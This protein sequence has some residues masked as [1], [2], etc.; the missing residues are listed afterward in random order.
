VSFT[1]LS[2]GLAVRASDERTPGQESVLAA[3][4]E[5]YYV[6]ETERYCGALIGIESESS[7][8]SYRTNQCYG[9]FVFLR[10]I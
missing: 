8:V 5:I 6:D 4:I 1:E 9:H 2:L 3:E 7:G 10:G